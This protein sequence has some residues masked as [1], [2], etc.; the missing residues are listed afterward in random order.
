VEEFHDV[1]LTTSDSG[2]DNS[3]DDD[4]RDRDG[5]TT[6]LLELPERQA[7]SSGLCLINDSYDDPLR[8]SLP[9]LPST[10]PPPLSLLPPVPPRPFIGPQEKGEIEEK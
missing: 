8:N 1:A 4:D 2:D 5:Q 10:L 7:W 6:P 9:D 3:G